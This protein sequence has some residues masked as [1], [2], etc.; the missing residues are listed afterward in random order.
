MCAYWKF[1]WNLSLMSSCSL[2]LSHRTLIVRRHSNSLAYSWAEWIIQLKQLN[3]SLCLRILVFILSV[4]VWCWFL[5]LFNI[6][7]KHWCFLQVRRRE[8]LPFPMPGTSGI[9]AGIAGVW[10][11]VQSWLRRRSPTVIRTWHHQSAVDERYKRYHSKSG[12][13]HRNCNWPP[14]VR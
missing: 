3:N 4:F 14:A 8:T 10:L 11:G 5:Y 1:T 2:V 12:I 9:P 7:V 6:Q 13:C